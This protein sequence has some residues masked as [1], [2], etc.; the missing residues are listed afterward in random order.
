MA[1][2]LR[3]VYMTAGSMEE[4][5]RIGE[6]LVAERTMLGFK[7]RRTVRTKIGSSS[8]NSKTIGWIFSLD[9]KNW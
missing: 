5:R 1:S 8:G 4:A 6:A 3:L 2:E 9:V 7:A